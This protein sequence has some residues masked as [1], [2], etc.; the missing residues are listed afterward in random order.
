MN[1]VTILPSNE[2]SRHL[3]VLTH[4]LVMELYVQYEDD[5][6][7]YRLD[8]AIAL[9][10]E[11]MPLLVRASRLR[12]ALQ[13]FSDL[14]NNTAWLASDVYPLAQDASDLLEELE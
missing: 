5:S 6:D 12:D 3:A 2:H 7:S 8:K 1:N 9:D 10:D 11:V 4:K 13:A 14:V